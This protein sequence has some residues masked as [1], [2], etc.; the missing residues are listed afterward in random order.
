MNYFRKVIT[1]K[2]SDSPNVRRWLMYRAA[3][4]TPIAG[5]CE[6]VPGVLSGPEYEARRATWD[7][8]RQCKGLD[9]MFY[10]GEELLLYPPEWLDRASS[11]VLVQKCQSS[12]TEGIGIDPAEGGD[13]TAYAAINRW[14]LKELVSRKTPN[15]HVIVGETMAFMRKHG[16]DRDASSSAVVFDRGGGGKQHADAIREMGYGVRSVG[17]GENPHLEIKRGLHMVEARK[18][19]EED[20]YQYVNLRAQMYHELSQALDPSSWIG[21]FPVVMHTIAGTRH[22]APTSFSEIRPVPGET[23]EEFARR[24]QRLLSSQAVPAIGFAVPGMGEVY[25][26]LRKQMAVMP[27]Q[28]NEEGRYKLPPKHRRDASDKRITLAEMLDGESPDELDAVV[29]GFFG[30]CHKAK[31]GKVGAA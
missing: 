20:R 8:V 24:R 17:F 1:I 21:G 16:M 11:A 10:E 25:E 23:E 26:K 19:T 28:T 15:T 6:L 3:G 14:G 12:S 29:L 9:A 2:A 31:R 7:K 27:K 13:S 4:M 5:D 22:H 30:M 18:D